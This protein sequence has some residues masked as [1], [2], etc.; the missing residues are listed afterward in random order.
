MKL[1]LLVVL[2]FSFPIGSCAFGVRSHHHRYGSG[3]MCGVRPWYLS[4]EPQDSPPENMGEEEKKDVV[5]IETLDSPP[6]NMTEEEKKEVVGNLLAEDEWNGLTME[7]AELVRLSI[8]EDVKKNARE[9]LGKDDYKL[10]DFSKEVDSRVKD[11]VA[12][13][14]DKEEVRCQQ[15]GTRQPPVDDALHCPSFVN[16]AYFAT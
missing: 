3:N 10:G 7:L 1:F 13:M 6:E 8:V 5:V 12:L 9:F 16:G 15:D 14:R 11:Q 2:G 4:S